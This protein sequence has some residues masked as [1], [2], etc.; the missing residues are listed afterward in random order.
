LPDEPETA[1]PALAAGRK[2]TLT[3]KRSF[4]MNQA[5]KNYAIKRISDIERKKLAALEAECTVE[6]IYLKDTEKYD[7]IKSG[8][9]SLRPRKEVEANHYSRIDDFYDFSKFRRDRGMTECFPKRK[10]KIQ[11]EAAKTRDLV[12]F[13]T[14]KDALKAI[15]DFEK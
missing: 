7:L 10:E 13:G 5:Q 3:L 6:A 1:K 2:I 11:A 4:T 12:M 15:Q 8:K 14:E 9:V